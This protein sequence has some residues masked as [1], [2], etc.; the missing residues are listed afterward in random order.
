MEELGLRELLF[1]F[2]R[3][4][5]LLLISFI[6][7]FSITFG[8]QK[9]SSP[10]EKKIFSSTAS[11][12]VSQ[13][14]HVPS[15]VK[16]IGIDIKT[17]KFDPEEEKVK[18]K[19]EENI[20]TAL[21]ILGWD[22][23]EENINKLRNMIEVSVKSRENIIDITAYSENPS[24]AKDVANAV[25]NAYVQNSKK[26]FE[27]SIENA[28]SFLKESSDE[29][30]QKLKEMYNTLS[31]FSAQTG[32][33]DPTSQLDQNLRRINDLRKNISLID[34]KI[35]AIENFFLKISRNPSKTAEHLRNLDE[36]L[37][38]DSLPEEKEA[39][40]ELKNK[41]GRIISIDES[42][43]SSY[44]KYFE[45]EKA[46]NE[47][48]TKYSEDH[49][50]IKE[51]D[52]E[53]QKIFEDILY[54]LKLLLA[55]LK[56]EK[57]AAEK[58]IEN[59]RKDIQYITGNLSQ[60][61]YLS[62]SIEMLNRVFENYYN[63][64]IELKMASGMWSQLAEV[65]KSATLPTEPIK[66]LKFQLVIS[67][68]VAL[69]GSVVVVFIAESLDSRFKNIEEILRYLKIPVFAMIPKV[70]VEGYN[71]K[72]EFIIENVK[73]I[74]NMLRI[75][76]GNRL[77]ILI[78]SC[79]DGEGKTFLSLL[80]SRAF[81]SAGLK[82]VIIDLNLRHP[83][84]SEIFNLPKEKSLTKLI[85]SDADLLSNGSE[86]LIELSEFKVDDNLS[87]FGSKEEE[88]EVLNFKL[89]I[90]F[91]NIFP[92]ILEKLSKKF[93]VVI[94]DSPPALIVSDIF[95][96]ISSFDVVLVVYDMG[97]VARKRLNLLL[98][99]LKTGGARDIKLVVNKVTR[100]FAPDL[101][102]KS[103]YYYYYYRSGKKGKK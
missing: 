61:M 103:Y 18:I 75:I 80:L 58:E 49:P 78:T 54:K 13:M 5:K 65:Y 44:T 31:Q 53:I 98:D 66:R 55:K 21:S 6:L 60:Y 95:P 23:N 47:L 3:R 83:S 25:A 68:L 12:R 1:S 50:K 84:L 15:M 48:L 72:D 97:K 33:I 7:L 90:F 45:L 20:K 91:Q 70:K 37:L 46:R 41:V 30:S 29:L 89:D 34:M 17:L 2:Y 42:L 57:Q 24:E 36:I 43:I 14:I 4:R 87:L 19:S 81:G 8:L 73:M 63:N 101:T 26:W 92:G 67:L 77:K 74:R 52:R 82:T 10:K 79:E 88:G 40:S 22:V 56:L 85:L 102:P 99:M 86:R 51:L 71:A 96:I 62:N 69:V 38:K 16:E 28:I 35:Q 76:Y 94:A 11:V 93:D 59:L 27:Q 32:I 64:L 39:V 100:E 9:I